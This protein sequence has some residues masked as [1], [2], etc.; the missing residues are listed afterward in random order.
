MSTGP[1]IKPVRIG[2]ADPLS[3]TGKSADL[4]SLFLLREAL[5][6]YD[7]VGIGLAVVDSQQRVQHCNRLAS[8]ILACRDGLELTPEKI[9]AT[10]GRRSSSS[11]GLFEMLRDA[12]VYD[13]RDNEQI[14]F[15]AVPRPSGKRPLTV[16]VRLTDLSSRQPYI[17]STTT[18][19][20]IVDSELP[21]QGMESHVQS[22]FRLTAAET[23]LAMRLMQGHTLSECC[24]RMRI[25]RST[26]ASHLRHLFNKTQARTQ[27]QLV[28]VLFR[29]FGLL[30]LSSNSDK[31]VPAKKV[32]TPREFPAQ[33]FDLQQERS[34]SV[35]FIRR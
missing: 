28:S 4:K 8:K 16:L 3:F 23:D 27:S 22:V 9:L 25:R 14:A 20:F 2:A 6:A 35:S 18:L 33:K 15:L 7:L 5:E 24:Q 21:M 31:S 1:Q 10:G 13:A 17:G 32:T 19:V 26:A 12:K 30:N 11:R 34:V 29:R